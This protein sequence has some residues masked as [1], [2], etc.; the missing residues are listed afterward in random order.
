MYGIPTLKLI[1]LVSIFIINQAFQQ[2]TVRIL[3][4]RYRVVAFISKPYPYSTA[5]KYFRHST[6]EDIPF[7]STSNNIYIPARHLGMEL[8]VANKKAD[9]NPLTRMLHPTL[10]T[11][12]LRTHRLN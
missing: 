6:V 5:C 9:R 1:E 4:T 10:E 11:S 3:F 12:V 2:P 8:L 7:T